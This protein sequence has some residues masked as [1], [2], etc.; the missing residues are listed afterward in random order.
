MHQTHAATTAT[1]HGLH[2]Q[3]RS[4][5]FGLRHEGGVAL[6][7]TEVAGQHRHAVLQRQRLGGRLAAQRANGSRRRADP[8]QASVHHGLREVGVFAEEA[9]AGVHRIGA[10]DACGF[11]QTVD[12]QIGFG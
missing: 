4:N 8:G 3:G 2:H 10:G 9:V 7:G 5:A 1:G 11:Q 12:A 6:V